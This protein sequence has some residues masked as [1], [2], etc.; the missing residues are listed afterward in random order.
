MTVILQF[1]T[2]VF[3]H[4]ALYNLA[5]N[6]CG[7]LQFSVLFSTGN[8]KCL[9][10]VKRTKFTLSMVFDF[11]IKFCL[12][13]NELL[14]KGY[15]SAWVSRGTSLQILKS[16]C[17][18]KEEKQRKPPNPT[19]V[20]CLIRDGEWCLWTKTKKPQLGAL[21]DT[22]RKASVSSVLA[23]THTHLAHTQRAPPSLHSP[24]TAPLAL[25]SGGRP[26]YVHMHY[27]VGVRSV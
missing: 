13:V 19:Q 20:S 15:F 5:S 2:R 9:F 1:P 18:Q 14:Q 3:I 8:S 10:F 25:G 16:S 6:S 12:F 23:P 27:L 11:H 22:V 17:K 4:L 7:S 21:D 24:T 26:V